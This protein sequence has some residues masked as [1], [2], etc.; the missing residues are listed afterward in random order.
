[1]ITLQRIVHLTMDR[2]TYKKLGSEPD[3]ERAWKMVKGIAGENLFQTNF[4]PVPQIES[5]LY[6]NQLF[7]FEKQTNVSTL[8]L[9]FK[10]K[11]MCNLILL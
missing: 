2:K 1:M 5:A 11:K 3:I 10:S 9:N 8:I 7:V 4:V 6:Y